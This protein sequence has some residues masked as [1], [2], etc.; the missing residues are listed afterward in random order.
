MPEKFRQSKPENFLA[1]TNTI[2]RRHTIQHKYGADIQF[3]TSMALE[4]KSTQAWLWHGNQHKYGAGKQIKI[5]MAL[6][7]E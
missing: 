5:I 4:Y 1:E 2:M 7:I 6:T 3:N